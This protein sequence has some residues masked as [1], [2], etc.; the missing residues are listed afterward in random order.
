MSSAPGRS[1]PCVVYRARSVLT[2][3]PS[4]PRADAVAVR[5]GRIAGVGEA[6]ALAAAGATIDD[7]Y[8]DRV[9]MPGLVEAHAHL[10][11]G[12]IW[13]YPYVGFYP[14][15][16]PA[17]ALHPGLKDISAVV[18]ALHMAEARLTDPDAPLVAWG[19]DPILFGGPRVVLADL[20]RASPHRPIAVIH[21]NFH[22]LN[23]NSA[24]LVRA[25]ITR[26]TYV[27]G[28]VR[29][30]AGEP[31]GELAELAAMFPVFRIVGD[32][33]AR[34]RGERALWSFARLAQAAGVTTAIDI[35]NDLSD[36]SVETLG[37]ATARDDFPLRLVAA[38]FGN[39][40]DPRLGIERVRSRTAMNTEKLRF[41]PAKLM[42]DGSIQGFTARLKPPGYHDGHPNGLWNI[43]PSE[44][45]AAVAAY[46]AA[47]LQLHIH[48]N[49][50]EASEVAIDALE[51]ALARHPRADHRHTLQHCQM[52]DAAQLERMRALGL[53]VNLFSNHIYYWGDVHRS[54]TMGPERAERMDAAGTALALGVPFAMH[55]DAPITPMAP[56]FTAWCAV[57]RRT[58]SG[59]VL[60][61]SE[62]IGVGEALRAI[63]LGA[64][65]TLRLEGEIGSIEVG[66][67]ADFAVLADD[68]SAVP[69][70][71][72][73]DVRVVGTMVGG[74]PFDPSAQPGVALHAR[75]FPG[76]R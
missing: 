76:R 50:D 47:G 37:R 53:C 20:D 70:E 69:P 55:S 12:G 21:A 1:A 43:A 15:R 65:Y 40:L 25:R 36:E 62:R 2:M 34:G 26:D 18:A 3:N 8:A 51:H 45:D 6:G 35:T 31:T 60:G 19:L 68:P 5:D 23:V 52:A 49:G 29:D 32:P 59:R 58:A 73:K 14:R 4:A 57:N 33:F 75:S 66:K 39:G 67:R 71:V 64:A 7:R 9:L 46:H 27:D 16:S 72:L 56:L 22:A 11:E 28:I 74:V 42:T 41:G 38:L 30:A 13:D 54:V 24:M 17:G 48:V 10:L 63:T 61:E 44:L